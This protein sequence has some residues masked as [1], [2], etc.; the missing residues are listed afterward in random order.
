MAPCPELNGTCAALCAR[1]VLETP[2]DVVLE[3]VRGVAAPLDPLTIEGLE[4]N[5]R[6][7]TIG[8]ADGPAR[9]WPPRKE[10]LGP[11]LP[12]SLLAPLPPAGC[13]TSTTPLAALASPPGRRAYAVWLLR[14]VTSCEIKKRADFFAPFVMVSASSVCVV[15]PP[16]RVQHP[17]LPPVAPPPCPVLVRP[18]AL[19]AVPLLRLPPVRQGLSDLDVSTFCARCVDPMGEEADHVQLVALTDALQVGGVCGGAW[20]ELG[21]AQGCRKFPALCACCCVRAAASWVC[22]APLPG[23][24]L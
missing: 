9:R 20:L 4:A 12:G 18:P 19:Q 16:A 14:I 3:M 2:L 8:W 5:T 17:L 6:D 24:M 15:A 1:A 21:A 7:E 22:A 10:G 23:G 13:P 11:S